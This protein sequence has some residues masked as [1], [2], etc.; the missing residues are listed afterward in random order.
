MFAPVKDRHLPG[1]GFT[2]DVG[3]RVTISCPAL[4]SL[5]NRVRHTQDCPPWSFGAGH[6][7][8]NLARR[9]LLTG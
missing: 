5:V 7:M 2:H 1:G 6:L 9:G 8:R 3:D 4:G